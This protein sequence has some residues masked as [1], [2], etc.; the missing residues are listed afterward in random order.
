MATEKTVS[1]SVVKALENKDKDVK[2]ATV[3]I[4]DADPVLVPVQHP[5]RIGFESRE[6]GMECIHIAG[7]W[8]ACLACW[9]FSLLAQRWTLVRSSGRNRSAISSCLRMAI[10]T[11][12]RFRLKTRRDWSSCGVATMP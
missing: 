2:T 1:H 12:P 7:C 11:R 4:I 10:T 6:E 8:F 5:C 9:S 3:R